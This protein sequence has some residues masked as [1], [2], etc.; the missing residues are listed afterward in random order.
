M[1]FLT[2]NV[3]GRF[4]IPSG[5]VGTEVS[6]LKRLAKI[7]EIGVLTTKSISLERREGNREPIVAQLEPGT[8][9]NAV[10]LANPGAEEFRRRLE[11]WQVP[12][13]KFLLISL[14]GK[15][16]DE[17]VKV[18]EILKDKADGFEINV[19]CPHGVN[20]G[21]IIGSDF[22]MVEK[23][24]KR[25]SVFGKPVIVKISPNLEVDKSVAAAVNGGA[26]GIAAINTVGP[27]ESDILSFGR[28]GMSG[29]KVLEKGVDVIGKVKK[30]VED[31][32]VI[33]ASGGI[34]TAVDA[35]RY[36]E[37]GA[38]ILSVGSVLAGMTTDEIEEYFGRLEKDINEGT[39]TAEELIKKDLDMKYQE[40][41]VVENIKLTD[42]LCQLKLNK[43]FKA[44]PG[45]FVMFFM[46]GSGEKPFS[47]YNKSGEN[48]EILC[49]K[50]GCLTEKMFELKKGDKIKVRGPYGVPMNIA[51]DKK[52][53]FVAGGTG[54]AAAKAFFETYD[55]FILMVGARSGCRLSGVNNWQGKGKVM[56]YTDDGTLGTKG[57]ATNDVKK[58]VDEFKPDYI[59]ACGPE[60]M[61][62]SLVAVLSDEDLKKTYLMKENE[63]KCGVGICGRCA[64]AH[65][66]R[67][68]VDGYRAEK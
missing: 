16:D 43:P 65:G 37:A 28:G 66:N 58:V 62:K 7:K 29:K 8:F 63:T 3:S 5:I 23:I 1:K 36:L 59:L 48:L 56:C 14:V 32:L 21:Q 18:A 20:M 31:K 60:V 54:V 61:N 24:V 39:N 35:K 33:I 15:D 22:E 50:R 26:M 25:I 46:P 67:Y 44:E 47:F 17:F 51:K 53:L 52:I 27:F 57:V 2:K 38:D 41:E 68:C 13:D 64:D 55:N 49:S 9:I 34:S 19:S 4:T 11:G 10:G 6:T 42:D 45:Q 30:L 40:M 12:A